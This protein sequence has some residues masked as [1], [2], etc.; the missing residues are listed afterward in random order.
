M[1]NDCFKFYYKATELKDLLRQGALQWNVDKDRL[2]SIAEH[3][4]GCMILAIGLHSELNLNLDLGKT[5]EMLT[6][7][8]LEELAIGDVTPL[9]NVDKSDLQDKARKSVEKILKNLQQKD[10]LL[11]LTDEYN[12]TLSK[13]AKFAKAVDKLECVLEFKKYQDMG[14]VSLRNLKPEM[15]N[16]KKVKAFVESGEYDLA[17][18]FFFYHMPAFKDFGIDEN[19][20]YNHL[21]PLPVRPSKSNNLDTK[22]P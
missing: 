2:E 13:E 8:E 3:T 15:L 1:L 19:Y 11:R 7:H 10:K 4:Y 9:D 17:D 22:A 14:Q 5:L 12:M 20:W 21:K 16:N 18:I 6:I